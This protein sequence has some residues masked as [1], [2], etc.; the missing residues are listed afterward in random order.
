MQLSMGW[1][2]KHTSIPFDYEN[3]SADCGNI[4]VGG[5]GVRFIDPRQL[6]VDIVNYLLKRLILLCN[7]CFARTHTRPTHSHQANNNYNQKVLGLRLLQSPGLGVSHTGAKIN[8]QER[9]N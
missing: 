8:D 6:I 3:R 9:P 5:H 1:Q 4:L 7:M 2:K